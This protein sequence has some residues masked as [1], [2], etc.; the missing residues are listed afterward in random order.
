MSHQ[1]EYHRGGRG[2]GFGRGF[3]RGRGG[4]GR[5]RGRFGGG[6]ELNKRPP[7]EPL[8]DKSVKW[9]FDESSDAP[10]V[11]AEKGANKKRAR[12][13][14]V[15]GRERSRAPT[16]EA[17]SASASLELRRFKLV[18]RLRHVL[19]TKT[20]SPTASR[21]AWRGWWRDCAR[22]RRWRWS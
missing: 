7:P 13:Y 20:T 16:V 21:R 1:A 14:H 6:G 8:W 18:K 3:G 19:A 10:G 2:D 15:S 17:A 11:G 12:E 9:F 22:R 4:R 5:G